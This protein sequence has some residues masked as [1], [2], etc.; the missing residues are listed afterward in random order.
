VY[1]VYFALF[2]FSYLF[3]VILDFGINNYNN[4]Q[5]AQDPQS[6]ARNL[7]STLVLKILLGI[8]YTVLLFIAAVGV[9][10]SGEQLAILGMLALLQ[11]ALSFY[12]FL[13][14]NI[15]AL[16]LFRTDAVL[17]VLDKLITSI[18]CAWI[19]WGAS[20]IAISIALFIWIQ[21]GGFVVAIII[22]LIILGRQKIHISKQ[23]DLHLMRGIFTSSMPYALLGF[24]MTAYY[25]TDGVM[26]ERLLGD[27][28][29]YQAGIYA[30]AFR[31]LDAM[32]ILGFLMA[33]MLMPMFS[34][35][36]AQ[37]ESIRPLLDLGYMVMLIASGTAGIACLVHREA[38]MDLLYHATDQSTGAIFGWLMVSFICISITYVYGSLIT[39]HGSIRTLNYIS[40]AGFALNIVLNCILIPRSFALGSAM[41]T[42]YSQL[43]I[44]AAHIFIAHRLFALDGG[45]SKWIRSVLFLAGILGLNLLITQLEMRW[46]W[47]WLCGVLGGALLA[48]PAGIVRKAELLGIKDLALSVLARRQGS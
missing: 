16:H 15:N 32:S 1:G 31:L 28:G 11:I 14:S 5:V 35:M 43:L 33:G 25:R 42:V 4:R 6:L 13:R 7:M 9:Q 41:A 24:L 17:S 37:R 18:F 44:L 22:A 29:P 19:L 30:S 2:N 40:L 38:I 27:D 10:F 39:A 48:I 3:Q 45:V 46:E 20:G 8:V 12:A 26:L 23:V 34:R 47:Q 21:I 36:L